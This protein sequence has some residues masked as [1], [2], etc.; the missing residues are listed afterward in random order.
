MDKDIC[1]LKAKIIMSRY[2]RTKQSRPLGL[3]KHTIITL[4]IFQNN[5]VEPD[6]NMGMI[7]L[8]LCIILGMRKFVK[9]IQ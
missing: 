5:F 3:W 6:V 4:I 8:R 9:K 1:T 2:Y 7:G